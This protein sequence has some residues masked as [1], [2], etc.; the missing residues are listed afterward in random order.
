MLEDPAEDPNPNS[1]VLFEDIQK[2]QT[3]WNR[4]SMDYDKART[5]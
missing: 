3:S 1:T 4:A 5:A 2:S